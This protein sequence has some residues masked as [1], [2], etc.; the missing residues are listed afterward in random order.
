MRQIARMLL[1]IA[2]L[3]TLALLAFA[4]K[5]DWA[6]V[7]GMLAPML[8]ALLLPSPLGK[9]IP[10]KWAALLSE[11]DYGQITEIIEHL[12]SREGRHESAVALARKLTAKNI[13]LSETQAEWVVSGIERVYKDK[14]KRI[15]ARQ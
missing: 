12:G 11:L 9:K 1:V 2:F 13:M 4:G 7:V 15:R 8:I 10:A 5:M 14:I 6:P 3:A